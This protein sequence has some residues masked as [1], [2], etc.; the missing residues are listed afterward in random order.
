MNCLAFIVWIAS[1][2]LFF[3]Q[4]PPPLIIDTESI[5]R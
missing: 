5:K 4:K 1:Q 2:S 3:E